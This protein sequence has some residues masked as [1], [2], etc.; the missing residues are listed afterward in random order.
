MIKTHGRT[1]HIDVRKNATFKSMY[2]EALGA[3]KKRKN[4][5]QYPIR[6]RRDN[7]IYC[8]GL[9]GEYFVELFKPLNPFKPVPSY[10]EK[11][12]A[13]RTTKSKKVTFIT[14]PFEN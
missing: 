5:A 13:F 9:Y 11:V 4:N 7:I 3:Q 14:I 12:N 6:V 10:Y 1:E 2:H 8:Y